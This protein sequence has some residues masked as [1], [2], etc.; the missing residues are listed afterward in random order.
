[1][2]GTGA[3]LSGG[4]HLASPGSRF[5]LDASGHWLA[6]HS[7]DGASEWAASLTARAGYGFAASG[8]LLT[9]FAELALADDAEARTAAGLAFAGP[10]GLAARLA[11]EQRDPDTRIGMTLDLHF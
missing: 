3:E 6:L 9:P 2:K 4:A 5:G 8:G 1:M 7:D 11:A 10:A